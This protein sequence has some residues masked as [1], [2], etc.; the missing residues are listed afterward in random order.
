LIKSADVGLAP[1]RKGVFT[2]G[3]VPTKLMEYAALKMPAI[4]A[5]TSAIEA[6]FRDTM[7]EFFTPGDADDLARCILILYQDQARLAE[8]V[9][10]AATFNQR[11][12]WEKLGSE[13]VHLI[14]R[15]NAPK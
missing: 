14:D 7:V 6:Y 3:I 8:L 11:Y 15:L 9:Q 1:Y 4:A 12:N 2:N 13:Y 5:R 10:G